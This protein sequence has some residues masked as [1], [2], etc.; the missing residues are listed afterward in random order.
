MLF[1]IININ[2]Q[3]NVTAVTIKGEQCTVKFQTEM[4]WIF[5]KVPGALQGI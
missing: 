2:P 4:H 3:S 5:W 1:N